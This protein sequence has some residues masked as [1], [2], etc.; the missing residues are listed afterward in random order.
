MEKKFLE[1]VFCRDSRRSRR[2]VAD[3]RFNDL[4]DVLCHEV[5]VLTGVDESG[6]WDFFQP[7]VVE[8]VELGEVC[9]TN[10]RFFRS[11]SL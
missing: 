3:C 1:E 10:F 5:A 9:Q 2:G 6:V 11:S 4:Q 8:V 7:C